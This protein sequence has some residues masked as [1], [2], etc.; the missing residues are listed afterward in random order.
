MRFSFV[1]SFDGGDCFTGGGGG[2]RGGGQEART[3]GGEQYIDAGGNAT[4]CGS[5]A[6]FEFRPCRKKAGDITARFT[7]GIAFCTGDLEA[8][9]VASPDS[10]DGGDGD[11]PGL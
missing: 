2:G 3:H 1:V 6:E 10:G 11:V 8:D 7:D 4:S 5:I 9:G